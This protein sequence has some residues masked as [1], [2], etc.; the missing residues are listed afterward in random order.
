[1]TEVMRSK[2]KDACGLCNQGAGRSRKRSGSGR[3]LARSARHL[4]AARE[5][6]AIKDGRLMMSSRRCV[7]EALVAQQTIRRLSFSKPLDESKS[8][9]SSQQLVVVVGH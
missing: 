3:E 6:Y 4:M 2:D 1:M 5:C 8:V 7:I 9:I